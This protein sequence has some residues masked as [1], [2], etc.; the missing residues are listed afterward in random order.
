MLQNFFSQRALKGKLE[1]RRAL[2]HSGTQRAHGHLGTQA[3]EHF[4]TRRALGHSRNLALGH[5]GI[6]GTRGTF[7]Y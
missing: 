1:T 6:R 4:G 3:I 5:L 2:E 7:I